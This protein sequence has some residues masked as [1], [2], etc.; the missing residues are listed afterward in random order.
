[1]R[2][3]F[4][5]VLFLASIGA[6]SD[7]DP[8]EAAHA[9]RDPAHVMTAVR[10]E[11]EIEDLN[12]HTVTVFGARREY[13]CPGGE[14]AQETRC[15]PC[16]YA[17]DAWA[18]HP[19]NEWIVEEVYATEAEHQAATKAIEHFG[20]YFELEPRAGVE[21]AG[22]QHV[23]AAYTGHTK[24]PP[25]PATV[26]KLKIRVGGVEREQALIAFGSKDVELE[27]QALRRNPS[28]ALEPMP[29]ARIDFSSACTQLRHTGEG[30][31]LVALA[32]G[33]NTCIVTATGNP[34]GVPASVSVGRELKM[35]ILF[36]G[37]AA[38]EVRL[39]HA[40]ALDLTYSAVAL[41][42]PV[43]I[44]PQWKGENGSFE[45]S[46]GGKKARFTLEAGHDEGSV[47]LLDAASGATDTL[48]VR[49]QP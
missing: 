49:R 10:I 12:K 11:S 22:K 9:K 28:G 47:M 20:R 48:V 43:S 2:T 46:E 42:K 44:Q 26:A 6:A 17:R 24:A 29:E 34:G 30:R 37:Q 41:D 36:E 1:M 32:P 39:Q 7:E 31:A 23:F 14:V 38:D 35:E 8:V 45:L 16:T 5:A 25:P 15:D 27:V 19:A 18:E 33:A 21:S 40:H 4:C 3:L 13:R